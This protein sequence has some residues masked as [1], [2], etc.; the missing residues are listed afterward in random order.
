MHAMMKHADTYAP[1]TLERYSRL[2]SR[3]LVATRLAA[4][5]ARKRESARAF[6]GDVVNLCTIAS[7]VFMLAQALLNR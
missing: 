2:N 3:Y 4:G 7:F 1:G 5:K 6:L